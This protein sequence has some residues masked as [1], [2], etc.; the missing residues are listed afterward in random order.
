LSLQGT[1]CSVS[2]TF[3]VGSA[4]FRCCLSRRF[5]SVPRRLSLVSGFTFVTQLS[6]QGSLLSLQGSLLSLQGSLLS[7]H[8]L[9]NIITT[10]DQKT[11]HFT[12][13]FRLEDNYLSIDTYEYCD[14]VT[15]I[16]DADIHRWARF[17][18]QKSFTSVFHFHLQQTN[19]S[20][21]FPI[22][23]SANKQKLAFSPSSVIRLWNSGDIE[24]WT[25]S[26]GC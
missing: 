7:L 20:W 6:L 14:E 9:N 21:P 11:T 15:Q 8:P 24:T 2:P 19:R 13:Y 17:L 26:H 12:I 4:G 16:N 23:F 1:V 22:P 10:S 5:A 3:T 18:K 25:W